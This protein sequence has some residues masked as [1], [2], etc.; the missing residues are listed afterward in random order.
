[1][2]ATFEGGF[3]T[4]AEVVAKENLGAVVPNQCEV[5]Y[6]N[7][8]PVPNDAEIYGVFQRVF[9]SRSMELILND[10]GS[11]EDVRFLLRYVVRDKSLALQL[12]AYRRGRSGTTR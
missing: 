6:I 5:S 3:N 8:I 4:F 11:P 1:M 7:Q 2:L 9:A 12:V 10:L